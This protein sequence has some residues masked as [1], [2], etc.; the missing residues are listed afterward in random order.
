LSE[1]ATRP[2]EPGVS[3]ETQR[4]WVVGATG[5]V[6]RE[7]VAQLRKRGIATTAHVRSDSPRLEHWRAHFGALGTPVDASPW[8]P[9]EFA[10][11]LHEDR[12]TLLF[13]CLGTTLRRKLAGSRSSVADSYLNVDLGLSSL[14]IDAAVQSGS[15]PRTILVSAARAAAGSRSKYLSARGKLEDHLIGSGL[16]YTIA[17][18]AF[19]TGSTRE[20]FRPLERLGAMVVDGCLLWGAILGMQILRERYRSIDAPELSRALVVHALDPRSAGTL[21]MGERL[22]DFP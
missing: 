8:Q 20:E 15:A 4:A 10:R 12:A 14:V 17:R 13:L 7:V 19:V 9:G 18:P 1:P 5:Y 16:P 21:L 2:P 22:R 6:G 11:R 3:A